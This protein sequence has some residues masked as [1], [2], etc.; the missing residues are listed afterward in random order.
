[1]YLRK[2]QLPETKAEVITAGMCN[3]LA[4]DAKTQLG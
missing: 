4:A 3:P 2:T 1:M